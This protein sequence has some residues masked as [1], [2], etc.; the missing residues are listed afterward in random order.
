M[1]LEKINVTTAYRTMNI[2]ETTGQI[3]KGCRQDAVLYITDDAATAKELRD[4]GEPVLVHLHSG[5]ADQDFSEFTFAV[6]KPEELDAEYV[7]K[8]WLRL[9]GLPWNILETERLLVRETM[10]QDVE[11]F[12][13][14]YSDPSI[15]AFMED[16]YPDVEE[17]KRYV[18]DYIAKVYTFFEFGVWTVVEK[19]AE[20]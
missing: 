1:Y 6:E 13:N 14:I 2:A 8:V 20:R 17:E 4:R 18:R 7:E 3:E 11:A 16:L 9:K 12:Y 5:N 10:E 15:T 19:K